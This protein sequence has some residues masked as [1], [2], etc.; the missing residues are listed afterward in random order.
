MNDGLDNFTVDELEIIRDVF[1]VKAEQQRTK[2]FRD[3]Y[4]QIVDKANTQLAQLGERP[5]DD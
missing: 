1:N 2:M 3:T 4:L 5:Y